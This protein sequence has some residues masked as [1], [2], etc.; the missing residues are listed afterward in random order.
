M[1][2]NYYKTWEQY[3]AEHPEIDEKEAQFMAPKMQSYEDMLFGF[4]MFL[5]A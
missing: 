2:T 4:I 5:C 1:E 3:L